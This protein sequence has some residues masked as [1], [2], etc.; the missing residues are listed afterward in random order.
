MTCTLRA[1]T[2]EDAKEL[3]CALSWRVFLEFEAPEYSQEQRVNGVRFTPMCYE[4]E[5]ESEGTA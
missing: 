4:K 1:W 5:S 2:T 3:A